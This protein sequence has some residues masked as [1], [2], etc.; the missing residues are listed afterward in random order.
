M[1]TNLTLIRNSLSTIMPVTVLALGLSGTV[2]AQSAPDAA[3]LLKDIEQGLQRGQQPVFTPPA[4]PKAPEQ[5]VSDGLKV[6]VNRITFSGTTLIPESELQTVIKPWIGQSLTSAELNRVAEAV[7]T[8]YQMRGYFARVYLPG[9]DLTNGVVSI[10]V[11]EGR[12]GAVR[13]DRAPEVKHLGNETVSR[14][15]L[16]QQ[17]LSAPVQP[18]KLHRAV[19]L[20]NELPGVAA[21]FVLEPGTKEGQSDVVVV[22]KDSPRFTGAV[23]VDNTGSKSTGENRITASLNINSPFGM[24]D[25]I[26]IA[27]NKSTGNQFA[28]LGYSI[29]LAYNG[30]RLGLAAS[31]LDYAYQQSGISYDGVAQ[32][33]G[34]TL[35]YPLLR[36]K[37]KNLDASYGYNYKYFRN[38]VQQVE[39]NNKAISA[40][41]IKVSG[42]A[43]DEYLGGGILQ[44]SLGYAE[45][46]L[47][48]GGNADD[49]KADQGAGS[50]NRQGNYHK[51]TWSLTR[52][53]RLNASD[54]LLLSAS[55]QFA[56]RNLDP[57]EKFSGSGSYAVRAF[58]STESSGDEGHLAILELRRQFSE[59]WQGSLFYDYSNIKR[60][61]ISNA[62]TLAPNVLELAGVGGSIN[63]GRPSDVQVKAIF[64][65][66]TVSTA[67]PLQ[68]DP[69]IWIN[70]FK[71]L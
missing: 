35:T 31:Q 45:G 39:S 15:V 61:L 33:S 70:I 10:A 13:I 27:A 2:A 56:G 64:A 41:N 4:V 65:W 54:S 57:A 5:S 36:S 3:S 50:T 52:I 44:F 53:Q 34:L 68:A 59:L 16:A 51:S 46:R 26:Q 69:K 48:L 20:L 24:G 22:L 21:S 17:E 1:Q 58:D 60:D 63:W 40:N 71:A 62:A 67:N 32:D 14:F 7:A 47:D 43:L 38:V 30:L 11:I 12:V 29:P 49:L 23:V 37:E 66:Q 18:A 42:D 8:A 19:T 28:R 55:G 9:Q 25:Q 6:L